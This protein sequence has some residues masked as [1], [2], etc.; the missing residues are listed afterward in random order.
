MRKTRKY[1][2]MFGSKRKHDKTIKISKSLCVSE[3]I[4]INSNC[5]NCYG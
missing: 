4:S 1:P 5:I 2:F 3:P